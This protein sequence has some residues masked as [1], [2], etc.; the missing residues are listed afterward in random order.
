MTYIYFYY[1]KEFIMEK[2]T[3]KSNC[4]DM[5]LY[6]GEYGINDDI[7]SEKNVE[8][9]SGDTKLNEDISLN[10]GI[11]GS[12]KK[13]DLIL[14]DKNGNQSLVKASVAA[15]KLYRFTVLKNLEYYYK[16]DVFVIY[17]HVDLEMHFFE[18]FRN[19]R[20]FSKSFVSVVS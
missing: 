11:L 16:H 6:N 19:L 10:N 4:T 7:I 1:R 13:S 9:M 15:S 12:L 8:I 3:N 14:I 20:S 18:N 2:L 5:V 17:N